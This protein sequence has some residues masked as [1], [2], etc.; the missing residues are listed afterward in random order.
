MQE[1]IPGQRWISDA[2]LPMGLGTVLSV[3]GRMITI[4][5]LATGETRNYA[6]Q[7]APLTRVRFAE[8]DHIS[9]HDNKVLVVS[10]VTE[11]SGLIT[12]IGTDQSGEAYEW[13]KAS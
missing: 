12:Y 2:E 3:E 4:V 13:L 8:G 11:S 6:S 1:Y 7:T 10:S 9:N 5:F